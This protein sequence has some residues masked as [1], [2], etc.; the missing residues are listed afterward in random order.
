MKDER[1]A[2]LHG[3]LRNACAYPPD[4]MEKFWIFDSFRDWTSGVDQECQISIWQPGEARQRKTSFRTPDHG[5]YQRAQ[6]VAASRSPD[7]RLSWKHQL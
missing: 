4:E 7:A 1:N 5:K 3:V 2:F 6:H